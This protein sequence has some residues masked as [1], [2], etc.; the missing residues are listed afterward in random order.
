MTWGRLAEICGQFLSRRQLVDVDGRLQ[1]RQWNDDA[2]GRN[3]GTQSTA[4][5]DPVRT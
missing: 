1:A 4:G 3:W 5:T 2:G